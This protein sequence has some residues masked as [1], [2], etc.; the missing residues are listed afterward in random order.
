[1]IRLCH[2]SENKPVKPHKSA[3]SRPARGQYFRSRIFNKTI[4]HEK[5]QNRSNAYSSYSSCYECL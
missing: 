4:N 1:M 3:I 5:Q 2:K